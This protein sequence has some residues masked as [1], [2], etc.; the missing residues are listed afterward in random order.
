MAKPAPE[1]LASG[2]IVLER[3]DIFFF[4]RPKILQPQV[5]GLEDIAEFRIL[6]HPLNRNLYRDLSASLKEVL[7]YAGQP[8][9]RWLTV[10]K[11]DSVLKEIMDAFRGRP[12]LQPAVP[13]GEGVYALVRHREHTHL[14][15]ALELPGEPGEAQKALGIEKEGNPIL[16]VRNP[17][18]RRDDPAI[19]PQLELPSYPPELASLLGDRRFY[20]ADPATFLDYEGTELLWI[21]LGNHKA[22]EMGLELYPEKENEQTA[23]IFSILKLRK[24]ENPVEPLFSGRWAP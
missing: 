15:Y 8:M 24:E 1:K 5:R 18:E 4:Y 14:A 16:S 13:C 11:V 19:S 2:A 6:L 3:G 12:P 17:L 21:N 9:E 10:H 22:R 7:E 20:P 23:E